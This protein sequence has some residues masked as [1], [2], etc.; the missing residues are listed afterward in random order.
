MKRQFEM[1]PYKV[2]EAI[3]IFIYYYA[4]QFA[5]TQKKIEQFNN[6]RSKKK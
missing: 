2:T 4:G 3:L 1:Q 6:E 5:G